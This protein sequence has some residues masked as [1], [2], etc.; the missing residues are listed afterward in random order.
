MSEERKKDDY[1][2]INKYLSQQVG[3]K[4]KFLQDTACMDLETRETLAIIEYIKV[5]HEDEETK[6]RMDRI[7][8][9][10]E[11]RGHA[12]WPRDVLTDMGLLLGISGKT[13]K[14]VKK[15]VGTV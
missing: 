2:Q 7:I 10:F 12:R 11:L 6:K 3:R 13:G 4:N 5:R 9:F 1:Y 8:P 15:V 14:V